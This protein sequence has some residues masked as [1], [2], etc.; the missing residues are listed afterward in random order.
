MDG[1]YR[2]RTE[3]PPENA[4]NTVD[5]VYLAGLILTLSM[6]ALSSEI[7]ALGVIN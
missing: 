5:P 7:Q 1:N 6:E 4:E 3:A 2:T